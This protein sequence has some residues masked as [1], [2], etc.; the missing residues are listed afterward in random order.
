MSERSK[1]L[2]ELIKNEGIQLIDT[3]GNL[4]MPN[5]DLLVYRYEAG[6]CD[7]ISWPLKEEQ[8]AQLATAIYDEMMCSDEGWKDDAEIL[9]PDG[10]VFDLYKYLP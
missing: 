1:K 8:L 4:H 2:E 3:D 6:D 5:D 9:L 10:E 7:L